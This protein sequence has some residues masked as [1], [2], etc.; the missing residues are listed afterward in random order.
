MSKHGVHLKYACPYCDAKPM[1]KFYMNEHILLKHS[2]NDGDKN[3][4]KLVANG[5]NGGNGGMVANG[6][7]GDNGGMV[8]NGGNMVAN[9]GNMVANLDIED[10]IFAYLR[11]MTLKEVAVLAAE[12]IIE[13]GFMTDTLSGIKVP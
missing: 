5:D 8:G 3:G 13:D 1:R 4:G 11:Q 6:D 10:Q 9:G 7:N 12:K 2:E